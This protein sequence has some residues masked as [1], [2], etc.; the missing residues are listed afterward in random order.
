MDP[1]MGR[2]RTAREQEAID[3]VAARVRALRHAREL[4]Q[5]RL[6]EAAGIHA[7]MVRR[8]EAG[9]INPSLG[10]LALVAD[11]LETTVVDLVRGLHPDPAQ[12]PLESPQHETPPSSDSP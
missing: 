6:G 3:H 12:P 4:T 10:T 5:D 9:R 1:V 7:T 2:V 11:A 8:I